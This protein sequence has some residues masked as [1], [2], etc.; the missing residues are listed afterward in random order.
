MEHSKIT[1]AFRSLRKKGYFAKQNFM[2]CQS[3]G[4]AAVP[5]GIEKVVFYHNQDK[6][7]ASKNGH[8]Y[9]SWAGDGN[10]IVAELK[11]AGA[12]VEWDGSESTRI[13]VKTWE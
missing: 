8:V 12:V 5:E 9:M 6:Q 10:E 11:A 2:C 1:I 7:R 13:L 4:F 3:C